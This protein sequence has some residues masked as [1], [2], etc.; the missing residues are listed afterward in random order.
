LGG[1]YT[2]RGGEQG[3]GGREEW[4]GVGFLF[5]SLPL[6]LSLSSFLLLLLLPPQQQKQKQLLLLLP[7]YYNY[8]YYY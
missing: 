8:Y 6:S 5:F 7:L 4:E 2:L 3:R 1:E